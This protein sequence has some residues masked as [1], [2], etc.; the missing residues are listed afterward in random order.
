MTDDT[1][2]ASP[3]L[4]AVKDITFGSVRSYLLTNL[5]IVTWT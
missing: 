1:Y 2:A 5:T 3:A 4:R